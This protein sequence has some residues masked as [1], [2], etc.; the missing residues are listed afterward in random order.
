MRSLTLSS[1][2][3]KDLKASGLSSKTIGAAGL[4]SA[5][6]DDLTEHFSFLPEGTTFLVFPYSQNNFF[7]VKCFPPL[8]LEGKKKPAKYLQTTGSDVHLYI[9]EGIEL[10]FPD[11]S[12]ELVIVEGEK[13]ALKGHQEGLP[14]CAVG[15]VWNWV[16]R[17]GDGGSRPIPELR[18]IAWVNRPVTLVFDSDIWA[19][20]QAK[21][22]LFA[23]GRQLEDLGAK[24]EVVLIKPKGKQKIG[25]DDYLVQHSVKD[26]AKLPRIT[27]KHRT[28]TAERKWYKGWSKRLQRESLAGELPQIDARDQDL[29]QVTGRAWEVLAARN[30]PPF[31]FSLSSKVFSL[32]EKPLLALAEVKE[33]RL[34]F[35]LT[36]AAHWYKILNDGSMVSAY[37]DAVVLKDM[38][39]HPNP[40]LP[41]IE[42]IAEFPFITKE[43][44]LHKEP[45]YSPA[46]LT[47]CKFSIEVPEVP[48]VPTAK[49]VTWARAL[50]YE[51]VQ[52][53]PFV[54]DAERAHA[55]GFAVL[56]FVREMIEGPTPL[57]AFDAPE[58]G[59]GKS[60][61]VAALSSIALGRPVPSSTETYQKDEWRKKITTILKSAPA[62]VFFDNV[63]QIL[64]S[65][66][67]SSAITS[68]YWTD[69]ILGKSKDVYLPVRCG[70]AVSGNNLQLSS[71][72]ARR[73][74][75][76]RMDAWM[77][78][79]WERDLTSFR[80]PNLLQ[81]VGE[82]RGELIRAVLILV[83]HWIAQGQPGAGV[84]LGSFESWAD[85]VGG[86]LQAAEV[87]GFL[88]NLTEF[89]EEADSEGKLIRI[90]IHEWWEEHKDAVVGVFELYNL[91]KDKEIPLFLGKT[92]NERGEKIYLGQRILQKI[93]GRQFD[94]Y[95]VEEAGT[96][97]N[98]QQYKLV[99]LESDP[100][101]KGESKFRLTEDSPAASSITT[102]KSESGESG[103]SKI[104]SQ[105]AKG[106][107]TPTKKCVYRKGVD[108]IID[109]P[110]SP[111]PPTP[112]FKPV[113]RG[114]SPVN[115]KS[116][117]NMINLL[118][119]TP[120]SAHLVEIIKELEKKTH[121]QRTL[122]EI[123]SHYSVLW[124]SA[125]V[126]KIHKNASCAAVAGHLQ[127]KKLRTIY[128][129]TETTSL[130]MHA[131]ELSLVQILVGSEVFL[132]PTGGD[133]TPLRELMED[134]SIQVVLHNASF[135]LGFLQAH[136]MPDLKP[137]NI[138]DTKIAER[139]LCGGLEIGYSLGDLA[140]R[141]LSVQLIKDKKLTTSFKPGMELNDKQIVYAAM[142]V[143]VLVG[144]ARAQQQALSQVGLWELAKVEMDLVP[145]VLDVSMAGIQVD[146]EML[147]K[148]KAVLEVEIASARA[149]VLELLGQEVNLNSPAQVLPA[150]RELGV[151]ATSTQKK[152][153]S[154]IKHPVGKALIKYKD[155]TKEQG[156]FIKGW[157]DRIEESTGRLYG[158]FQQVGTVTGRLSCRRPNLQ[159]VPRNGD[160]RRAFV[161]APGHKL[162]VAD[163]SQVELR[164]VAEL[165]GDPVL[166]EA[167]EGGRDIHSETAARVF[168]VPL[169]KV[170]DELRGRAKAINFGVIYGLG[171]NSL[172]ERVGCTE[173][174]ARQFYNKYFRTFEQLSRYRRAVSS[175]VLKKPYSLTLWRRVR[176]YNSP[177]SSQL[178]E[179]QLRNRAINTPVQGSAGD[180]F[181][182]A[183]YWLHQ[184]LPETAKV[185]NL[186]HDEVV[187]EAP[188][189]QVTEVKE[190]IY[191]TLVE[192]G[193]H[194]LKKVPVTVD[195]EIRDSWA[196]V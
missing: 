25:L 50:L 102:G 131:G 118:Q 171:I 120:F 146:V 94:D 123:E 20:P 75:R 126:T 87:P 168:N 21:Q 15:G 22:G 137:T 192:A 13:K 189:D 156:T 59:T 130:I 26:F 170:D 91:I 83:R 165:S 54:G 175:R 160:L 47:Y 163:Y 129:D 86:I 119:V 80:H 7:R 40:P 57:H 90:F 151:R 125:F 36:R 95:R 6:A 64:S 33:D 16:S 179:Y 172:A 148:R 3:R 32:V 191:A 49:D 4:F 155:C 78:R 39:A 67:L 17:D 53:M 34:R 18:E 185:V 23:L 150:L 177:N 133:F 30:N 73:T 28:F 117:I 187:V 188:E 143:V 63:N 70:W 100:L 84:H 43:G 98:A 19:N 1:E 142:D 161:A 55:L 101:V 69:R 93:K 195:I 8:K 51:L 99:V 184:K 85:V 136:V 9:P 194:L 144:I 164:I 58:P 107:F 24:I 109:S 37:P 79:P 106:F 88:N 29:P 65:G 105:R 92:S 176:Y 141:Y 182:L 167:F 186:I 77:D 158:D 97:K 124:G 196:K 111:D 81:W 103:E 114:G 52:D 152:S 139:V 41:Q 140:E 56:P 113:Y 45:G 128:V 76:I 132:I 61:L 162:I 74:I 135:D 89:Y 10:L 2:H 145:A 178:S 110:D 112:V 166:I 190:I 72:L 31:L 169:E 68:T 82:H 127:Q 183:L 157:L 96:H 147:E 122:Q 104:E 44:V 108:R 60:L 149:H 134:P 180:I 38:L 66:A 11:F 138:W 71:E 121:L 193:T 115:L 116:V 35:E 173:A 27:L 14:C 153:L 181:K 48:E 5:G 42:K 154:K 46:S 159:Q 174:E 12:Q 62:L